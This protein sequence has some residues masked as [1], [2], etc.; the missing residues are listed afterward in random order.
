[1]GLIASSGEGKLCQIGPLS[2]KGGSGPVSFRDSRLGT[3]GISDMHATHFQIYLILGSRV[4]GFGS[5]IS[6]GVGLM[7]R[8]VSAFK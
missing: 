5:G 7:M 4:C 1:M 8:P 3:T 2:C 6:L